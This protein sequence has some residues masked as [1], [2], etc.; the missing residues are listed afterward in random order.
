MPASA[1]PLSVAIY[2]RFS[3]DRQNDRS[4]ADQIA[5]GRDYAARQNPPWNVVATYSDFAIS[6]ASVHGRDEYQRMLADADAGR[7]AI[8]LAEDVDR[9]A[10]NAADTMRLKET[11]DFVGV[12]IFTV[13][14]GE[15]TSDLLFGFKGIMAA[16][17]RKTHALK[18][19][20][21]QEGRVRAGKIA[22]GLSY[23]Y[24]AV[25]GRPGEREIVEAQAAIVRRIFAAYIEG[26]TPREIVI[27]LNA[28]RVPAPRG[29][30]WTTSTILGTDKR[31]NGILNN[32]LYCGVIEWN[33]V[34]MVKDPKTGKRQM[35]I[36]AGDVRRRVEAPA[37]AIVSREIFDAAQ[38][39]RRSRAGARPELQRKPRHVLS[40]LLR[41]AGCGGGLSVTGLERNG[42]NRV[43]CSNHAK[44]ADCPAP[45]TFYL[46]LIEEAVLKG[47]RAELRAPA[48]IAEYVRTYHAER[49][50]LVAGSRD[51]RDAVARRLAQIERELTNLVG[52]IADGIGR[53]ELLGARMNVLAEEREAIAVEL[54]DMAKPDQVIALHPA[55]L[56]R[57]QAQ[58]ATLQESLASG[59]AAGD[60]A[61][62]QALRDLVEA[63]TV[64]R[65]PQRA[66]GLRIAIAGRLDRILG[67]QG[68]R[69]SLSPDSH[70]PPAGGS[71][72]F[73]LA[74][75]A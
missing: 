51:R 53:R 14:D 50:R 58:I 5:L 11:C 6:G 61:G 26:A 29:R 37:L 69:G 10:R 65:D 13:A 72:R 8:L 39:R 17:W 68:E 45:A 46:D 32:P 44:G 30:Q 16:D 25:L 34:R 15:A 22:S 59:L 62:A 47:L 38:A 2:A 71:P 18:I 24:A 35:R 74:I 19:R 56:D 28:E 63:V 31:G 75:V 7:F 66:G 3:S 1:D 27:R 48:V 33:R 42:R 23:G 54:A 9:Y 21:G 41:C 67:M 73:H 43:R 64:S 36:N 40:G 49:T 70:V 57:Y 20:R 12:R 55:A 4:I 52:A 60:D